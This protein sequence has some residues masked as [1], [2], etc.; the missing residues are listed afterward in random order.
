MPQGEQCAA[1][2]FFFRGS[3]CTM[4]NRMNDWVLG[5][6]DLAQRLATGDCGGSYGDG[7][8][9]LSAMVSSFAAR[10]WPGKRIDK[11]RF[12]ELWARYTDPKLHANRISLPLLVAN[13]RNCG[14][15]EL[16]ELA[17]R[18]RPEYIDEIPE[19]DDMIVTG[20]QVDVDAEE[21]SVA[22]SLPLKQL[23]RFSYGAVFYDH[24]R[25]GYVHEY[26]TG[27]HGDEVVMSRTR[28]D[29]TYQNWDEE[30]YRRI[31]FDIEWVAKVVRSICDRAEHDWRTAPRPEPLTWWLAGGTS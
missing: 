28:G 14:D 20:D 30:P 5:K 3:S 8:L 2:P 16:A 11:V 15:D 18:M 24:F 1:T 26:Q 23:H 4:V 31:N 10:M 19:F 6:I 12:V 25:S 21:V 17:R 13:L 9:I 27:T 22:T 29:I 7:I